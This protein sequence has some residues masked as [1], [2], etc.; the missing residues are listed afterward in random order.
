MRSAVDSIAR[1]VLTTML[2]AAHHDA[3]TFRKKSLGPEP[4]SQRGRKG[5]IG[6][7]YAVPA[8]KSTPIREGRRRC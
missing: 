8:I 5:P 3:F 1:T 2:E 4:A 7:G 6:R